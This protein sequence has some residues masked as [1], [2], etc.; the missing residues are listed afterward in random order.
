MKEC[1]QG[2]LEGIRKQGRPSTSYIDHVNVWTDLSK[3]AD[4]YR[5]AESRREWKDTVRNSTRA[6]N[7]EG[8]IG[9]LTEPGD[10][11]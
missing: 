2:T 3:S 9:N 4:V 7:A 8:H 5:R 10:A 11:D 6:V 1:I